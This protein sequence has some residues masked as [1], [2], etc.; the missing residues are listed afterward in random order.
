M[1]QYSRKIQ[2]ED[3]SGCGTAHHMFGLEVFN[4]EIE[5]KCDRINEAWKM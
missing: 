4:V 1:S 3:L 5:F 2:N